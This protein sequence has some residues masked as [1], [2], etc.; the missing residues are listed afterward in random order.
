MDSKAKM[1]VIGRVSINI[2]EIAWKMENSSMEQKLPLSLQID[3]FA[4][5]ATLTVN[6]FYYY[7]ILDL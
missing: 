4:R 7:H 3:G 6:S 2:S 5:D 1:A